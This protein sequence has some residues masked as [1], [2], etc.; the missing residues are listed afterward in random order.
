MAN[1]GYPNRTAAIIHSRLLVSILEIHI[2]FVAGLINGCVCRIRNIITHF[3]YHTTDPH[4]RMY[5]RRSEIAIEQFY[6]YLLE[7]AGNIR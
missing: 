1:P 7:T 2:V 6:V 5:L 3:D 4:F